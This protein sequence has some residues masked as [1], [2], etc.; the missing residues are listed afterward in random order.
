MLKRNP[1]AAPI[2]KTVEITIREVMPLVMVTGRVT[3]ALVEMVV[4]L[5]GVIEVAGTLAMETVT[6]GLQIVVSATIG[7]AHPVK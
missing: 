1:S 4:L 5:V 7:A 3:E 6:Q 2:I